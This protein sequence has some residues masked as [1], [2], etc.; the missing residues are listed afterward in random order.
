MNER[1]GT[2]A[3]FG[4]RSTTLPPFCSLEPNSAYTLCLAISRICPIVSDGF[5]ISAPSRHDLTSIVAY[6]LGGIDTD[7]AL[8][9]CWMIEEAVEENDI[10]LATEGSC[11]INDE[12]TADR[13]T[14]RENTAERV[15]HNRFSTMAFL[16]SMDQ[17]VLQEL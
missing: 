15:C 10:L 14:A 3:S 16:P 13:K 9:L 8:Q 2:W 4:F 7:F 5:L 12:A 1:G 11:T 17:C 6:T